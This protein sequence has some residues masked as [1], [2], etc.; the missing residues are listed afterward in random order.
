[1]KTY[2]SN[3]TKVVFRGLWQKPY[4]AIETVFD[5]RDG[6]GSQPRTRCENVFL[7]K[8]INKTFGYTCKFYIYYL[9]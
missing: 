4:M 5:K 3:Q 6:F 7:T 8:C 2:P 9:T 1:M